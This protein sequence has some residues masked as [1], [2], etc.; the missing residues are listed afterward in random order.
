MLPE[1]TGCS[2]SGGCLTS[3]DFLGVSELHLGLRCSVGNLKDFLSLCQLK[4]VQI[5][6]QF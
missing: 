2:W 5:T 1:K 4:N 3:L 6:Q